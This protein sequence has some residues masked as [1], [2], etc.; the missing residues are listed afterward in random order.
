MKSLPSENCKH[1]EK[2]ISIIICIDIYI[3]RV[4]LKNKKIELSAIQKDPEK[5]LLCCD[6]Q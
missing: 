5:I 2:R 6:Y 4:I 1:Y 3:Q